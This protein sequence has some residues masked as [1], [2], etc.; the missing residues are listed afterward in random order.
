MTKANILIVVSLYFNWVSELLAGASPLTISDISLMLR[1]GYSS[2]TILSTCRSGT[3][4]A[5][6]TQPPKQTCEKRMLLM[7]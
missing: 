2:E 1:S 6:L 4:P 7:R 5:A 3:L